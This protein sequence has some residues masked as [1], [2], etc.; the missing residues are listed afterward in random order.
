[1]ENQQDNNLKLPSLN[2]GVG[3]RVINID[4]KPMLPRRGNLKTT[5]TNEQKIPN[6]ID[7][8]M[9]IS[10]PAVNPFNG[11]KTDVR[12]ESISD[13]QKDMHVHETWDTLNPNIWSLKEHDDNHKR[14][15]NT[16]EK[17]WSEYD[18]LDGIGNQGGK[19]K[20]FAETVKTNTQK[21]KV[22]FRFLE[23]NEGMENVD[24]TIPIASV[25]NVQQRFQNVLFGYFLGKRL[26]FPMVDYFVKNRWKKYGLAK[27]MMNAKGFFFFK[28]NTKE[29]MEQVLTDGP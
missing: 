28:F 8:L 22:N 2:K 23:T 17:R 1:M 6:A 10:S 13:E 4:G 26:A 20:S 21:R 12:S 29:G 11:A 25:R 24:V 5:D 27:S 9:S 18:D 7:G 19:P 16:E 14:T 3:I 15:D